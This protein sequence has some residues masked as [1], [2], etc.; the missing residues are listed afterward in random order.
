M[1]F[2]L[3]RYTDNTLVTSHVRSFR[4]TKGATYTYS[5]ESTDA[6]GNTA[7]AGPFTHLTGTQSPVV[8]RRAFSPPLFV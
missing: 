5:V 2:G 1:V 4:G 6:A 7:T 8:K 3:A